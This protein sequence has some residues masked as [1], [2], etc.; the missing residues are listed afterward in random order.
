MQFAGIN[1]AQL[2]HCM[3]HVKHT[4]QKLR[5]EW[6]LSVNLEYSIILHLSGPMPVVL[7]EICCTSSRKNA[8]LNK[9]SEVP[10]IYLIHISP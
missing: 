9:W 2:M 1:T 6:V 10:N 5:S 7:P 3:E 8:T 4:M